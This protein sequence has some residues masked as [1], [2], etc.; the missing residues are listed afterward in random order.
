MADVLFPFLSWMPDLKKK[1]LR[2]NWDSFTLVQ[3][4]KLPV[5]FVTGT[6]DEIVPTEMSQRL[7]RSCPSLHKEL[8]TVEGG[9]HNDTYLKAGEA[10]GQRITAFLSKCKELS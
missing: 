4:L 5:L 7:L 1:M 10:Y 3:Q 2:L 8:L 6:K 9:T